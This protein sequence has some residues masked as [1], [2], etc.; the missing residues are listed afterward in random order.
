MQMKLLGITNVDFDIIDG[1][2]KFSSSVRYWR[3]NGSIMVQY[4][5]YQGISRKPRIQLGAKYYTVFSLSL[6]YL[7]K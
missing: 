6:E 3:K 5:S 2:I 1:L 7:G 4:I